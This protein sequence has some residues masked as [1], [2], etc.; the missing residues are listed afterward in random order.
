MIERMV[1]AMNLGAQIALITFLCSFLLL[2]VVLVAQFIVGIRKLAAQNFSALVCL[3]KVPKD[4]INHMKERSEERYLQFH[5]EVDPDGDDISSILKGD[6][7]SE[8]HFKYLCV[9][10]LNEKGGLS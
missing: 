1:D 9:Q 4:T 5:A 6:S 10:G 3:A 7:D 2:A 8:V